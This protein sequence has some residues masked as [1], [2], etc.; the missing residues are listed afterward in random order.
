[1]EQF[2]RI[3]HMEDILNRSAEICAVFE[4]ALEQFLSLNGSLAELNAYYGSELWFHDLDC[5]RA[6]LLPPDLRRG[7]LSEDAV[8]DLLTDYGALWERVRKLAA[9]SAEQNPNEPA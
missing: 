8:Y 3:R 5:D 1:M 6:G 9:E 2:D 4:S 7:V